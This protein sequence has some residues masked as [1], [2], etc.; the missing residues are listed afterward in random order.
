VTDLLNSRAAFWSVVALAIILCA[1]GNLPWHLDDYDQAKQAFTSF[2][3]VERGHWLYQ[4]TPNGWIA[5][6]PPLVGWISAGLFSVIRSW[7]LAWR[8]P[9]FLAGLAL[10]VL[11]AR[12]ATAY[13]RAAAFV[14]TCALGLNLFAPRLATLVRTDMPLALIV[15]A[16]GLLIWEKIRKREPWNRR[17]RLTLFLLLSAAMLIKGPIVY[18]FLL[19]GIAA[20]QWRARASGEAV[21]AWSGW[22][23]WLASLAV[24]AAWIAGGIF[25]V[26][27][28]TE[29][30]VLR[31]FAGRFGGAVHRAQPFYFYLPHLL[32]R[33]APWSILLILLAIL[34]VRQSRLR[35]R[36][37]LRAISPETFWLVVWS[38]GGLLVMSVV[39]S[40]RV[41]RVFPIVPP[42]CLLVAA[43][44]AAMQKSEK[45][46]GAAMACC[47]ISIVLACLFASGYTAR[48]IA[49]GYREK[50]DAFA[51]FG[52]AVRTEAATRHWQI[53]VV[54]RKD[55]GM[56]LYLR[57]TEFLD[58]E[59]AAV[60]WKA[61]YLDGLVVAE[62]E[63]RNLLPLL[64]GA[65]PSPIGMSE[66]AGSYRNRYIFLV[67]SGL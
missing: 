28:F 15:F 22:W 13:G 26:P 59:L 20:F 36:D 18:A 31:E 44:I 39:P 8:L 56:L 33:F 57:Q 24:F 3:M 32:H 9:S 37:A 60:K 52:K 51:D 12:A 49:L 40:K 35:V 45:L 6:K 34:G 27:E 25:F 17:D 62:D 1:I 7:N 54:G 58:P 48:R 64:P 53:A 10:L 42:L 63:L 14:A 16:I 65:A 29:H 43:Q 23:P 38:L 21:T 19:P 46:R 47:T 5:T 11:L 67:C 4:H 61:G 30:V 66:P 50:R 41:D 55:E 2:E